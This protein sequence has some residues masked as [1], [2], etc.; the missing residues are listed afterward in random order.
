M[1]IEAISCAYWLE[2]KAMTFLPEHSGKVVR[3]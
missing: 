3:S 2:A 1:T